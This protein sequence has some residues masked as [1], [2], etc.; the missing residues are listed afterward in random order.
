MQMTL[1]DMLKTLNNIKIMNLILQHLSLSYK[2]IIKTGVMKKLFVFL[3]TALFA[4]SVVS[5][6]APNTDKR[7]D[8]NT[9]SVKSG[10]VAIKRPTEKAVSYIS[11][12]SFTADFG[13]ATNIEWRRGTMYDEVTFT[14]RGK[15]RTAY[16]D[17]EGKMVG[18]TE[19]SSF[20]NLP[21]KGQEAI[22]TKYKDYTVSQVIFYNDNLLNETEMYLYNKSFEDEDNYFAELEN[23]SEKIVVKIDPEGHVDYFAK[24]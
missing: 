22:N 24:L 8:K 23:S 11:K 4:V 13:K 12:T 10:K 2:L 19:I 17:S 5:G 1:A 15:T 6:H 20:D 7:T 3:M 16:Y 14:I 21:A 9:K 18:T